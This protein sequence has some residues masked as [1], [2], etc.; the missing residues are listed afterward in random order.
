MLIK[1]VDPLHRLRTYAVTQFLF[2]PS[3]LNAAINRLGFV[4]ADPIRAP[5]PAQDLILRHRVAGYRAGDLERR[6]PELEIDEGYLLAYGFVPRALWHLLHPPRATGLTKLERRVL[7]L[8]RERGQVHPKDLAGEL[9][10][11]RAV[12][13][14]GGHSKVTTLALDELQSRGLIRVVRREAGIRVYQPALEP[15]PT[16][17]DG[18]RRLVLTVA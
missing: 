1:S 3:T 9:G 8:V 15:P 4:Q 13:A 16:A 17:A 2:P 10:S 18:L 5:A 12:N 14:W 7:D 6:Y 11:R